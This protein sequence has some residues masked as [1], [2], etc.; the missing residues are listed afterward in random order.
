MQRAGRKRKGQRVRSVA[1]REAA[2]T[3]AVST[4]LIIMLETTGLRRVASRIAPI[5]I[6]VM[7]PE[8]GQEDILGMVVGTHS[9]GKM[10]ELGLHSK[11]CSNNCI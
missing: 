7:H 5:G 1:R 3:Q 9:N 8:A 2:E 11:H 4:K 6:R 10:Q